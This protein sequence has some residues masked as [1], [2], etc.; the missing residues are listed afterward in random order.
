[1][2]VVVCSLIE[3][4]RGRALDSPE[5]PAIC[6]HTSQPLVGHSALIALDL[7][8]SGMLVCGLGRSLG[9]CGPFSCGEVVVYAGVRL[10]SVAG[11]T[12]IP[13]CSV[14]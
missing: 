2:G 4:R 3:G 7:T 14:S 9:K 13:A 11:V 6:T 1:M 8:V 10:C 12:H 5:T